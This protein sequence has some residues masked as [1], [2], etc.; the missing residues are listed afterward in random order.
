[1]PSRPPVVRD[2]SARERPAWS[3]P[4]SNDGA[5]SSDRN[6]SRDEARRA[7]RR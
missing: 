3:V 1:V 2:Q 4:R 6:G 5:R 7:W